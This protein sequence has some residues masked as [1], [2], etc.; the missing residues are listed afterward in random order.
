MVHLEN[1]LIITPWHP[2]KLNN[3]WVF[4]NILLLQQQLVVN[5]DYFSIDNYH[6]GFIN[7]TQCIMLGHNFKNRF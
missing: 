6:I 7:D 5:H 3:E 2:I 1:G 4:P